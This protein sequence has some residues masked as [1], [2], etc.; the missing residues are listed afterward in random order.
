LRE[1]FGVGVVPACQ[2]G[3]RD[4]EEGG[5][6]L[7]VADADE[8]GGLGEEAFGGVGARSESGVVGQ[9]VRTSMRGLG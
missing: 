8:F 4:A 7:D 9:G 3:G 1:A 2:G 5:G 6:V